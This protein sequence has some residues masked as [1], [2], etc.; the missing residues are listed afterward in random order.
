MYLILWPCS[1]QPVT[2][3]SRYVSWQWYLSVTINILVFNFRYVTTQN[4]KCTKSIISISNNIKTNIYLCLSV[5]IYHW[6]LVT[7]RTA[8]GTRPATQI[9]NLIFVKNFLYI[10]YLLQYL[11][12]HFK[13]FITATMAQNHW[14]KYFF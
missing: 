7:I 6:A 11:K 5:C 14:S 1:I 10:H 8:D 2:N 3:W 4:I 12:K 13:H 9:T